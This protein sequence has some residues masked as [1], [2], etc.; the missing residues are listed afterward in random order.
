[1]P[2]EQKKSNILMKFLSRYIYWVA[3]LLS[4]L[5]IGLGYMFILK[6]KIYEHK[7]IPELTLEYQQEILNQRQR[8]LQQLNNLIVDY[9]KLPNSHFNKINELLPSANE[10]PILFTHLSGLAKAND[11]VLLNVSV[12]ELGDR[13]LTTLFVTEGMAVT[14]NLKVID[15]TANFMGKVGNDSYSYFKQMLNAI[16]KNI[17]LFDIQYISFSPTLSNFSFNARTYYLKDE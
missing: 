1:M 12:S 14:K 17:R 9:K 2:I 16:A 15:V 5:L 8:K 13:N 6:P 3:G 7:K 11:T 10:A 4:I